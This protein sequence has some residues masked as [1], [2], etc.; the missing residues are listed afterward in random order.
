MPII[1][2]I[3]FPFFAEPD[4]GFAN[5]IVYSCPA[6]IISGASETRAPASVDRWAADTAPVSV[7]DSG[8]EKF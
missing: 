2:H 5:R 8:S 6:A 7:Q 1:P 4:R 3:Q